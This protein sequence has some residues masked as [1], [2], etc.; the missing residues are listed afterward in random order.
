MLEQYREEL[1]ELLAGG[2]VDQYQFGF[3]RAGNAVWS[4]R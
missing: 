4:L 2:Y 1:E 3:T